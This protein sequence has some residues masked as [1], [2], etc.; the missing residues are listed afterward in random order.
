MLGD[1]TELHGI[2]PYP[3]EAGIQI[4]LFSAFGEQSGDYVAFV[5]EGCTGG[6]GGLDM[7]LVETLTNSALGFG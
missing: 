4:A 7:R 2:A 3:Q 1:R 5:T 6:K